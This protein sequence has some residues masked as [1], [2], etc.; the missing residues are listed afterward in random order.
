M[1]PAAEVYQALLE[2]LDRWFA[3]G[4]AQAPDVIPCARGCTACCHGPF[5]ISMADQLLL[6]ETVARLPPEHRA[7]ILARADRAL[8]KLQ[9][10]APEWEAPWD[11]AAI[12]DDRFDAIAEALSDL[13]C[14]VLG[15]AG[16]CLAYTGRPLVCRLIGRAMLTLDGRLLE[17]GCPIQD[18]F[19]GYAGLDPV[20]F[21]LDALEVEEVACLEAAAL[22]LRGAPS[23]AGAETTIAACLATGG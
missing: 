3:E 4:R 12:G 9:Q 18:R 8:A 22:A 21:D 2:R 19:P 1:H 11:I 20:P 17:N 5:D 15:S 23:A 10:L 14:P 7:G 6:R 13:P 16:E